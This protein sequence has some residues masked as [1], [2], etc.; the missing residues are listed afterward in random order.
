MTKIE[1]LF[2]EEAQQREQIAG[3]RQLV[4]DI[5]NIITKGYDV[6]AA[7]DL[8]GATTDEFE[9]AKALLESDAVV[10]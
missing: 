4:N 7:C 5:N 2:E 1:R 6:N 9:K 3:A 10:A 8:V